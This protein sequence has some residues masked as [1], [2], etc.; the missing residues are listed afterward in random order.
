MRFHGEAGGAWEKLRYLEAE[1]LRM[2]Q[3]SG[4]RR[5]MRR[6]D[7]GNAKKGLKN[8]TIYSSDSESERNKRQVVT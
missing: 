1:K 3:R 4:G 6:E 5:A 8:G 2:H 7:A